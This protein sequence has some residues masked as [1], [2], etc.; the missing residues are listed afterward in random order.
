MLERILFGKEQNIT[1][2]VYFWNLCAGMMFS[3]QSAILLLAVKRAG[4]DFAGGVF[5]ILFTVP[6]MLSALGGYAMRDFQVSDVKEEYSFRDYYS[7]RV[8]TCLLMV[9]ACVVYGIYRELPADRMMVLLLL[10]GF[11]VTE[12]M[13]DVYHGEIQ[14][15]GRLDAA[16]I[17]V[18]IRVTVATIAFCVIYAVTTDLAYASLG[19][20][21]VSVAVLLVCN[22]VMLTVFDDIKRGWAA[23]HIVRLLM[24]CFPL[25]LGAILYSYL[26]NAPKYSIDRILGE[27]AQTIFNILFMPVFITNAVCQPIVKPMVKQ[28]GIWWNEGRSGSFAKMALKQAAV[29]IAINAVIIAGGYFLGCPIL[30][31]I[32][33]ADLAEYPLTLAAFL[34]FGGIAALTAYLAILLTVM[35]RQWFI[36]AGYAAG[37]I[38]SLVAT[39]RLVKSHEIPGAGYAYGIVM[40]SVCVSLLILTVIG[41][42][43]KPAPAK[44]GSEEEQ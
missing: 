1:R 3:C 36:I 24:V 41:I 4:G 43:T 32:Y 22:H 39:D 2:R 21:A 5:V 34:C 13:E 15:R 25:F 16:A 9:L 11:R 6:Q 40:G 12:C 23:K 33:H 17:S 19:M 26:V 20:T 29:I 18:T 10:A 37:Y 44:K 14:K 35:R 30:G 7:T 31:I 38:V 42:L 8:V 27:E 28:M